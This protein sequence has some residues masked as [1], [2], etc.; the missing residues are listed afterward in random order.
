MRRDDRKKLLVTGASGFL[1]RHVCRH[2]ADA[3]EV[4]GLGRTAAAVPGVDRWVS[5]DLTDASGLVRLFGDLKPDAVIHLGAMSRLPDCQAEPARS[6]AVN[7]QAS[8]QVAALSAER[9]IPCVFS[10]TDIV[11]DGQRPP[12]READPVCPINTYGVHKALAE[13]AML[14]AY[15]ETLV[16]RL[17]M[18]FGMAGKWFRPDGQRM[19]RGA[20]LPLFR[21]EFRTPVSA[22][23]VAQGML[24]AM[25][26]HR[27][28]L[29]LGGGMRVSRLGFGRMAA[30]AFGYYAGGI[31]SCR[32]GEMD[33][34]A[35]RPRDVTLDITLARRLGFAPL[36]LADELSALA[37]RF[38]TASGC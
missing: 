34:G 33:L 16:C 15:P 35:P 9:G 36:P 38:R 29:H 22:D 25:G 37:A 3:W 10:S 17:S 5:L 31:V 11:F 1:G 19:A 23:R 27:G 20:R 6:L 2:A 21:D 30:R 32:Q 4:I 26:R 18:V 12:Y 24:V 14:A 8:R 13:E 7:V 28:V